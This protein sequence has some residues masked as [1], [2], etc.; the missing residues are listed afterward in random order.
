MGLYREKT[1]EIRE[2][3]YDFVLLA[4]LRPRLLSTLPRKEACCAQ[5]FRPGHSLLYLRKK[6]HFSFSCISTLPKNLSALSISPLR[7]RANRNKR[8]WTREREAAFLSE[9]MVEEFF[10]AKRVRPIFFFIDYFSLSDWNILTDPSSFVLFHREH[11]LFEL[12][13]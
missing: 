12:L 9:A 7:V 10:E 11:F 3:S 1:G 2:R 4:F 5:L 8:S 13:W 6:V